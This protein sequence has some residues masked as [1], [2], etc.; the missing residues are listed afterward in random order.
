LQIA[1]N[2]GAVHADLLGDLLPGEFGE[3]QLH[4][5]TLPLGQRLASASF[6]GTVVLPIV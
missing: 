2:D 3:V 4:R 6:L 5:P 1:G